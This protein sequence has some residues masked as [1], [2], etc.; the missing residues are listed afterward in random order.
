MDA[1]RQTHKHESKRRREGVEGG[2]GGGG[3]GEESAEGG[4]GGGGLAS[5]GVAAQQDSA[6]LELPGKAR[7][8][9]GSSGSN[10]SSANGE[11]GG[12]VSNKPPK[13]VLRKSDEAALAPPSGF[14]AGS[15]A[16]VLAVNNTGV[17]FCSCPSYWLQNPA[18]LGIL[19]HMCSGGTRSDHMPFSLEYHVHHESGLLGPAAVSREPRPLVV[20]PLYQLERR[21]ANAKCEDA[22]SGE[23]HVIVVR[24]A[25]GDIQ[26]FVTDDEDLCRAANRLSDYPSYDSKCQREADSLLDEL[27][28][29]NKVSSCYNYIFSDPLAQVH[30]LDLAAKNGGVVVAGNTASRKRPYEVVMEEEEDDEDEITFN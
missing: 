24:T 16:T 13:L 25:A 8:S 3:A 29:A 4:G 1:I 7:D 9:S 18:L 2:G 21:L 14:S 15:A 23:D 27:S 10:G 17:K 5:A 20:L 22:V 6:T 19:L 26:T 30:L 12:A 28:K 11:N